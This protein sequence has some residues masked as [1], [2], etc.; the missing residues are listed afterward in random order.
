MNAAPDEAHPARDSLDAGEAD[1][2]RAP[3]AQLDDGSELLA[4]IGKVGFLYVQRFSGPVGQDSVSE[5]EQWTTARARKAWQKLMI[6]HQLRPARRA[7]P[8]AS[9]TRRQARAR[10]V[11]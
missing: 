2:R 7:R 3:R 11:R 10:T 8:P 9:S 6:L 4:L 1:T 5:L